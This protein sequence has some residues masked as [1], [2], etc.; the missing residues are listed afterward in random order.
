MSLTDTALIPFT[1]GAYYGRLKWGIGE[2]PHREAMVGG[3]LLIFTKSCFLS[4]KCPKRRR[5]V[6]VAHSYPVNRNR[7][8][9]VGVMGLIAALWNEVIASKMHITIPVG[10]LTIRENLHRLSIRPAFLEPLG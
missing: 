6:R 3:V 10:P 8:P 9:Y 7:P 1:H 4:A 2:F 5:A